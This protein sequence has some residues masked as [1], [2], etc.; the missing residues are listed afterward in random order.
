MHFSKS[1]KREW[2]GR[3]SVCTEALGVRSGLGTKRQRDEWHPRMLLLSLH[4]MLR[5]AGLGCRS[6]A[7]TGST[8]A[9]VCKS[10]NPIAPTAAHSKVSP[11]T[12]IPRSAAPKHE[13]GGGDLCTA[14]HVPASAATGSYGTGQ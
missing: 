4:L 12:A 10:C 9:A 3:Q 8:K 7:Y 14:T 11:G 5:T 6:D 1:G 2:E 13:M